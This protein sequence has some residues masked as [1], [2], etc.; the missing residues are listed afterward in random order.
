MVQRQRGSF[1]L[2]PQ[3]VPHAFGNPMSSASKLLIIFTPAD[4]REGYFQELA[5]L[6]R[7]GK[8]PS[9][10]ALIEVMHRYDQY[11]VDGDRT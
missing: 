4:T 11:L 2:V 9:R 7:D 1:V 3:G 6:Y 8:Q 10:E 5:E